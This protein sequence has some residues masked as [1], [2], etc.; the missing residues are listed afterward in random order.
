MKKK[1]LLLA[2]L[3]FLSGCA[4][5]GKTGMQIG[6]FSASGAYPAMFKDGRAGYLI[7]CSDPDG[8]IGRA[9]ALCGNNR[10]VL[11]KPGSVDWSRSGEVDRADFDRRRAN[12][13][14][15]YAITCPR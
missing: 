1:N 9:L 6:P 15:I 13:Q 14:T 2:G 11:Q 4:S 10:F 3:V 7:W 12:G 8:C 5:P